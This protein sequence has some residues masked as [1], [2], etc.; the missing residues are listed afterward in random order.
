MVKRAMAAACDRRDVPGKTPC[1]AGFGRRRLECR[2]DI[3]L[4]LHSKILRDSE[5]TKLNL[6]WLKQEKAN[7]F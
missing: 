4:K 7:D 1:V 5:F 6:T 3:S 2:P